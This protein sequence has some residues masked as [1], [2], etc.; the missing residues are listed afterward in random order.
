MFLTALSVRLRPI[1]RF[2]PLLGALVFSTTSILDAP[3]AVGQTP[4]KQQ[5]Q[6]LDFSEEDFSP[7]KSTPPVLEQP[8]PTAPRQLDPSRAIKP[9]GKEY[10][11]QV[12]KVLSGDRLTLSDGLELQLLGVTTP[13]SGRSCHGTEAAEFTRQAVVG[14]CVRVETPS[15]QAGR[16]PSGITLAYVYYPDPTG[17]Q[18]FLN[19]ELVRA[20]HGMA[21][22]DLPHPRR[23][24]FIQLQAS[25]RAARHGVWGACF[26]WKSERELGGF[27]TDPAGNKTWRHQPG[28]DIMI[29]TKP[30]AGG[31]FKDDDGVRYYDDGTVM[32]DKEIVRL[33]EG[34]VAP[35]FS[36]SDIQRA[37]TS[38]PQIHVRD[39]IHSAGHAPGLI[40]AYRHDVYVGVPS[41]GR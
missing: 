2:C 24:E 37:I 12:V 23:M 36:L 19:E 13:S 3:R 6:S 22:P 10:Q 17:R 15:G 7:G 18:V 9:C 41:G 39:F 32:R 1:L 16:D 8:P 27:G 38:N 30:L 28:I 33:A 35:G 11:Q 31:S 5:P 21:P 25:A 14:K 4:V 40:P 26:D 20:G 29:R 34:A